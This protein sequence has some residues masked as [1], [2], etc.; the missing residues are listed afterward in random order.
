MSGGWY[1]VSLSTGLAAGT[2]NGTH[3]FGQEIVIWRDAGG[4]V[5]A[6][7]D[8]CPHRGMRL[9]LGF[10]RGDRI[11]CLYH[12]WQYDAEARC[13]FIPAHPE[14]MPPDTIR[15]PTFRAVEVGGMVWVAP[16]EAGEPPLLAAPAFPVRSITIEAPMARVLAELDA[17]P[18]DGKAWQAETLALLSAGG[19]ICGLQ[20]VSEMVTALHLVLA[21]GRNRCRAVSD[22]S[23]E[24][25][26]KA[27]MAVVA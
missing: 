21:D 9:S 22:W 23:E 2:S 11:A 4:R 17:S 18:V 1:P 5:H 27:E 13:R 12:G 10:V 25:R 15:V 6:W 16:A 14:L 8:R 26:R 7:E 24:L 19:I 20:P 3:L